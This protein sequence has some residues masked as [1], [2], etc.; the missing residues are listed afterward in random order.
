ML[1]GSQT[2]T[3]TEKH[4]YT[5]IHTDTHTQTHTHTQQQLLHTEAFYTQKPVTHRNFYTHNLLH[6]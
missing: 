6:T 3:Y 1:I 2:Q 4:V 5:Y